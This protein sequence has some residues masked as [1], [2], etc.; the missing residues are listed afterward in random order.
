MA[1]RGG[2]VGKVEETGAKGGVADINH[3]VR[4]KMIDIRWVGHIPWIVKHARRVFVA[5]QN[6]R[7]N[8]ENWLRVTHDRA[9]T[10]RKERPEGIGESFAHVST[11][12]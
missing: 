2:G 10:Q 1:T 12:L 3:I 7:V 9:H 4:G 6:G 8:I 5:A 11:S